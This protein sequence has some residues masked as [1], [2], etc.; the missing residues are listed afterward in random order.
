M[1][2]ADKATVSFLAVSDIH[3]SWNDGID[4][5]GYDAMIVAGDFINDVRWLPDD[6]YRNAIKDT[7][8]FVWCRKHL[9]LPVFLIP[10]NHDRVVENHPEWIEWPENII[11]LHTG[12][13]AEDKGISRS[14]D[15]AFEFKGIRIFGMPWSSGYSRGSGFLCFDEQLRGKLDAM[16]F[17]LD[18]LVVH[19]PPMIEDSEGA[20]D[21]DVGKSG[22]HFGNETIR[23]A[24]I[25]KKPRLVICGHVHQGSREPAKLGETIVINASL[26]KHKRDASPAYSPAYVMFNTD[27]TFDVTPAK[28]I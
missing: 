10:G 13:G 16:P 5:T 22:A 11:R 24:I 8:F 3:N 19:G 20:S 18:I 7:S 21:K 4:P 26:V 2:S 27:G 12:N 28:R 23:S 15:G 6:E 14:A 1:A 17:N 25:A 9:D